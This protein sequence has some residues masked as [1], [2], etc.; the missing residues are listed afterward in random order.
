M[1]RLRA[2]LRR[3]QT[4]PSGTPRTSAISR[5][6]K[7]RT[8]GD[9]V[10]AAYQ[11]AKSRGDIGARYATAY[12]LG[13]V[14]GHLAADGDT[15]SANVYANELKRDLNQARDPNER[16]QLLTALGAAGRS[17]DLP[18][19]V[20][21]AADPDAAVR[22][23]AAGAL[24]NDASAEGLSVLLRLVADPIPPVQ[25]AALRVLSQRALALATLDALA[26]I[27]ERNVL[28]KTS[29]GDLLTLLGSR[30]AAGP[31]VIRM[32]VFVVAHS[33]DDPAMEARARRLLVETGATAP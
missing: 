15:A 14:A 22:R 25:Q 29:Y 32:L 10:D 30:V 12:S 23:A 33:E 26:E 3:D 16:A 7:A 19:I 9:F 1:S 5:C 8:S 13:A 4:V 20:V 31:S 27:V 18:T 21:M 17:E 11:G 6:E 28:H 2:A 24:R